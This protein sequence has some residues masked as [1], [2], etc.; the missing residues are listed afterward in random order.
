MLDNDKVVKLVD[1]GTARDLLNPTIQ[2]AGNSLRGK[3]IFEH[4]VGTP[5]YMAPECIRNKDSIAKS[6]I[7]SLGCILYQ[8]FVG[9]PPFM[10]GSEYLIFKKALNEKPYYYDFVFHNH[11]DVKD[12]IELMLEKDPEKRISLNEVKKHKFFDGMNF[13]DIEI[14]SKYEGNLTD[15]ERFVRDIKNE[16]IT[17]EKK[18]DVDINIIID[19]AKTKLAI[20]KEKD[21]LV[22]MFKKLDFMAKQ[23][24]NYFN[25]EEYQHEKIELCESLD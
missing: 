7:W 17:L 10:G 8:F 24:R 13:N 21:L 6:D 16:L 22:T 25:I 11:L 2:G 4:F 9:F 19:D 3:K 18:T 20:S 23:A 15:D 1:F 5:Q 12:L 14:Y